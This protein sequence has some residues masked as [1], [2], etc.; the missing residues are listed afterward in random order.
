MRELREFEF[1]NMLLIFCIYCRKSATISQ[2]FNSDGVLRSRSE[3][4][5][6]KRDMQPYQIRYSRL[7]GAVEISIRGHFDKKWVPLP[8]VILSQNPQKGSERYRKPRDRKEGSI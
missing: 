4:R 1:G 8:K 7:N 2:N 3:P 5:A 6:R